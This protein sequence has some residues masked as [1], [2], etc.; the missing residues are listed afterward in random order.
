MPAAAIYF[1]FLIDGSN[2]KS[3]TTSCT[4]PYSITLIHTTFRP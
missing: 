2:I 1:K 3:K 4:S